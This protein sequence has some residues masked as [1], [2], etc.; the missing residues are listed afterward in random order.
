MSLTTITQIATLPI[1]VTETSALYQLT[2]TITT[3]VLTSLTALPGQT[4]TIHPPFFALSSDQGM[5]TLGAILPIETFGVTEFDVVFQGLSGKIWTTVHYE[6]A[7][8]APLTST[9]YATA[10]AVLV[11]PRMHGGWDNWTHAE[12]G[13]M[14]A[15]LVCFVFLVIGLIWWCTRVTRKEWIV[16]SR[17]AD[18]VFVGPGWNNTASSEYRPSYWGGGYWLRGGSRGERET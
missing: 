14:I 16:H 8:A 1:V 2:T 4:I 13:G 10:P 12:K 15:G 11:A 5:P 17:P 3:H 18:T 9:T 6:T 7:A